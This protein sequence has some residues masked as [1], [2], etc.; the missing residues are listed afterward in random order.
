MI[1]DFEMDAIFA[2]GNANV[3][4]GAIGMAMNVGETFLHDAENGGL[5]FGGQPSDVGRNIQ[6][7]LDVAAL[8]KSF[9][10]SPESGGKAE[11]VQQRR[12][13]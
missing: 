4:E 9:D 10:I 6:K 1:L 12:V 2:A 7:D 3:G 13:K 8:R 5:E 11:V